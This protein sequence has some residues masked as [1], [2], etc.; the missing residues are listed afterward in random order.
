VPVLLKAW[1]SESHAGAPEVRFPLAEARGGS[2][3]T[4]AIVAGMHGGEYAGIL[5]AT[6]LIQHLA[7]SDVH[8]RVLVIPTMSTLAFFRRSMQLSPVD[9]REVHYLWPGH[10]EGSYSEHL[11][12]LVFRTIRVADFVVDMHAGEFVQ[13]LTPYVGVPWLDDGHLWQRSLELATAFDVPFI[14]RRALAETSIAL[15]RALLEVG[16]PNVWTEIG[17][18]GLPEP[19]A[20][21]LQYNGLVNMLTLLG[22]LPG[23]GVRYAP[24]W[25]GPKHWSIFAEQSGLWHPRIHG[26]EPVAAGQVLGELTDFFGDHLHTFTA[27]ADA[28]ATYVCTSPAV[29]VDNKP[30]GNDWHQHLVQLVEDV[31]GPRRAT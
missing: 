22:V 28:L 14:N 11:V 2:G 21:D 16:I 29:D 24:R 23:S 30:H 26:G 17:R 8:G 1:I 31:H 10:P 18:N 4:V 5:A 25:V 6:R 27:P 12:D 20:I 13:D 15:P 7:R 3:P 9:A 19:T